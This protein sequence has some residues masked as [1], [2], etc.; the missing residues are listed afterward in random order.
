M[1]SF[2]LT[3]RRSRGSVRVEEFGVGAHREAFDRRLVLDREYFGN[4][5]VEV[6]VFE[7]DSLQQLQATHGRYFQSPRQI[8]AEFSKAV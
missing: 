2:V 7:A 5:D 8:V 6:V 3:Y 4:W 1:H